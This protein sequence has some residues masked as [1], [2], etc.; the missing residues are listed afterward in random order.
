[1]V[2]SL[3]LPLIL[4]FLFFL[5]FVFHGIAL[6][7]RNGQFFYKKTNFKKL[8]LI[9][10]ISLFI[11]YSSINLA[12]LSLINCVNIDDTN[13]IYLVKSPNMKCW[14]NEHLTLFFAF[15]V[16]A[17]L[18]VSVGFPLFLWV[19]I[20]ESK[21]EFLTQATR[22][23]NKKTSKKIAIIWDSFM[24][25]PNGTE[26]EERDL[27]VIGTL[28]KSEIL[29]YC[30]FFYKDYKE[31]YYFWE[32]IIFLVKLILALV[33]NLSDYINNESKN[34]LFSVILLIYWANV[35]KWQPF[36]DHFINQLEESSILITILSQVFVL[37]YAST[38]IIILAGFS[39]ALNVF[40]MLYA[41]ILLVKHTNW[42][43]IVQT[44]KRTYVDVNS[45]I[46]KF[47]PARKTHKNTGSNSKN[48]K[49]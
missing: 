16:V 7:I 10:L 27:N 17:F 34:R 37:T 4:T 31:R 11:F 48:L 38:K 29:N 39:V 6:F 8:G 14:Q 40:F 47:A 19:I 36:K 44:A 2:F 23:T 3:I 1:M 25:I 42:K 24:K 45:A 18:I 30:S 33:S 21:K 28:K 26:T 49:S 20:Y 43:K 32:S 13:D 22:F 9:L 41:F 12:C 35:I 46:K 5:F 15:G